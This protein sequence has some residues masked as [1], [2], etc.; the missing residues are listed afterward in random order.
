MWIWRKYRSRLLLEMLTTAVDTSDLFA[1]L[2][3]PLTQ[4]N[5]G[6]FIMNRDE[7]LQLSVVSKMT[8]LESYGDPPPCVQYTYYSTFFPCDSLPPSSPLPRHFTKLILSQAPAKSPSYL[9]RASSR[10]RTLSRCSNSPSASNARSS[11][12]NTRCCSL[13]RARCWIHI[14]PNNDFNSARFRLNFRRPGYA[15]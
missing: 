13:P 7:R 15:C 6:T 9:T 2:G 1:I 5:T 14:Y 10:I 4:Q 3:L 11:R 8:P 12:D